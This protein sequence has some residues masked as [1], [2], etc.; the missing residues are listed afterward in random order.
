M[1]NKEM[2]QL[3]VEKVL[4]RLLERELISKEEYDKGITES[5]KLQLRQ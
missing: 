1:N 5:R 2:N 4:K 3:Y